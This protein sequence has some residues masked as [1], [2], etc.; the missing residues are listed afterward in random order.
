MASFE[1]WSQQL[2]GFGGLGHW[3]SSS[4]LRDPYLGP[5]H[6]RLSSALQVRLN[7]LWIRVCNNTTK[8]TLTLILTL[9]TRC[10]VDLHPSLAL[11]CVCVCVC[12]CVWR[13]C[14]LEG[15]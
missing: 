13:L 8:L 10:V 11:V 6:R 4:G 3:A 15:E 5:R 14:E 12:V 9:L 7:W 2:R 1:G